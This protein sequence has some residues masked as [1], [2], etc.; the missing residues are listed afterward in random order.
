MPFFIDSADEAV[1][2][3]VEVLVEKARVG[4]VC[5]LGVKVFVCETDVGIEILAGPGG[6]YVS[7]SSSGR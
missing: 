2:N 1:A 4:V 3:G 6:D 5:A 7:W